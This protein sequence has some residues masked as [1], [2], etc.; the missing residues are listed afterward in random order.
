M[1]TKINAFRECSLFSI[2]FDILNTT[3]QHYARTF[4]IYHSCASDTRWW[5][6][7]MAQCQI[8]IAQ[9]ALMHH[10][11][12]EFAFHTWTPGK[13]RK[14][15]QSTTGQHHIRIVRNSS[16]NISG[17]SSMRANSFSL[18]CLD[19]APSIRDQEYGSTNVT[20]RSMWQREKHLRDNIP[21]RVW[22][23]LEYK[24]EKYHSVRV[25][26]LGHF[27]AQRG[28]K[29][30]VPKKIP[31]WRL[32]LYLLYARDILMK[33]TQILQNKVLCNALVQ[34]WRGNLKMRVVEE[35]RRFT[36]KHRKRREATKCRS[37]LSVW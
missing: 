11:L 24:L 23:I 8:F 22:H 20:K 37:N 21:R 12:L 17:P 15:T 10:L 5:H 28:K 33:V 35:I 26:F 34:S 27:R 32:V 14:G 7:K 31:G 29:Y 30:S 16:Y 18:I 13:S 25:K 1:K 2:N 3:T 9:T 36:D 4:P 19:S 6:N